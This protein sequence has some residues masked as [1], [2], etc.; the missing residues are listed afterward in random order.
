[1]RG[2][3][4]WANRHAATRR[5]IEPED[6]V[7]L[8][9]GAAPAASPPPAKLPTPP[10]GMVAVPDAAPPP[11]VVA[12][13]AAPAEQA[14]AAPQEEPP[15]PEE[16]LG[17]DPWIAPIRNMLGLARTARRGMRAALATGGATATAGIGL[18]SLAVT[19]APPPGSPLP[20]A[21]QAMEATAASSPWGQVVLRVAELWPAHWVGVVAVTLGAAMVAA[22]VAG[23]AE[24]RAA[25]LSQHRSRD[26]AQRARLRRWQERVEAAQRAEAE[27][28]RRAEIVAQVR[29]AE[30]QRQQE[31]LA[32][33]E[34]EAEERVK[35]L[36]ET[37]ERRA[38]AERAE[39]A[40]LEGR[41]QSKSILVR[42]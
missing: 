20:G 2:H 41:R 3:P 16:D 21:G 9:P 28:Q 17:P 40:I 31:M 22:A 34:R 30:A 1:M 35:R 14:V 12:A 23:G 38:A 24:E 32:E 18:S 7:P 13:V 25:Q 19:M 8:E 29:A 10:I 42:E 6:L 4:G 27:S 36:E 26:M 11:E 39:R 5:A 33:A 37:A 15:P